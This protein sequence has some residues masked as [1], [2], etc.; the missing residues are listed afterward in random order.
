[1]KLETLHHLFNQL[2]DDNYCFI[3]NGS[4]TDEI[5]Q[6]FISLSDHNLT[7][8]QELSKMRKKVSFL[9]A[10]CFQNIVR[11][12]DKPEGE[13]KVSESPHFFFT[14]NVGK[15]YYIS[16][17]NFIENSKIEPLK[18]QLEK[19]N[20]L[21]EEGLKTI[22]LEVLGNESFSGKGGAGL[23]LIEMA[24][25]SGQKLEFNF[26][27]IN[28]NFSYFYLQIKLKGKDE[29]D[30]SKLEMPLKQVKE[31]HK[32]VLDEDI[33]IIH[34]DSFSKDAYMPVLKMF[35][36]NMQALSTNARVEKRA[37]HLSVEIVQNI[38]RHSLLINDQREGIF[39]LAKKD[40]Q[41]IIYAG[42]F[43]ENE[44]VESLRER[45]NA[46]N[47]LDREALTGL[48]KKQL[49]SGKPTKDGG[50][51]LGVIDIARD[52]ET[53]NFDFFPVDDQKSFFT[54]S[55]KL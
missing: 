40:E 30:Q 14:R 52:S 7:N 24:R 9:M 34:R 54:L 51:G 29:Q 6:M 26:K 16:S 1:M 22:Y 36:N 31:F 55:V 48:Y 32:F 12:S 50:A 19:V 21:D 23:G 13:M 47:G 3:Y 2:K 27:E 44:N 5:T 15:G 10:E 42:N 28:E 38:S 37:Y 17:A 46:L 49:R 20:E 39:I 41:Y 11:H 45:L 4:A 53:F 25:K 33:Y 18:L 8:V 43:I 35:E